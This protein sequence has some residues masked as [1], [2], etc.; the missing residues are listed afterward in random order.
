MGDY[1]MHNLFPIPVGIKNLGEES[2]TLNKQIMEEIYRIK[3]LEELNTR[4]GKNLFQTKANLQKTNDFFNNL[5]SIF[6]EHI[7]PY[8]LTAGI[9]DPDN[10]LELDSLWFN[11]NNNPS[12]YHIPHIHG[13]GNTLFSCVYYPSSGILDGKE[14]S[15]NQNLDENVKLESKTNIVPG[16][17]VFLDPSFV[18]KNLVYIEGMKRRP[19]YIQQLTLEPRA[20]IL[21][22]FPQYL[23]HYVVPT[24]RNNFERVSVVFSV[25]KKQH[26]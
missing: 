11:Y 12:A 4:S 13:S 23:P 22:S 5:N 3:D 7:K 9:T 2:R 18:A 26:K 6:F 15:D 10:S 21:V 1:V 17:I 8:L 20:G 14:L 25:N 24:E 19:Y 16:S